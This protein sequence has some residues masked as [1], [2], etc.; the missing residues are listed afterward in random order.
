MQQIK[1]HLRRPQSGMMSGTSPLTGNPQS[2]HGQEVA[3]LEV[4]AGRLPARNSPQQAPQAGQMIG[5][6]PLMAM[7]P[8]RDRQVDKDPGELI[9]ELAVAGAAGKGAAG[10]EEVAGAAETAGVRGGAR[11]RRET[12]GKGLTLRQAETAGAPRA[13]AARARPEVRVLTGPLAMP[14]T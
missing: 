7:H 5:T 4:P 14:C 8:A 13:E 6:L 9:E 12:D 11:P 1:Q 2:M 10:V 3:S